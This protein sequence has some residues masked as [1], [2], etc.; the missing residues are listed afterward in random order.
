MSEVIPQTSG[1]YRIEIGKRFYYGSAV[2]LKGRKSTHL[3]GLQRGVHHNPRLL[4]AYRKHQTFKF[5]VV[6]DCAVGELLER[7]QVYLDEFHGHP[8]CMNIASMAGSQLGTKRDETAR[9]KMSEFQRSRPPMSDE[10]KAKVVAALVGRPVSVE[11]R[12]KMSEAQKGIPNPKR[13]H[14]NRPPEWRKMMS[15]RHSGAGNPSY[16]RK[17]SEEERRAMS[18]AV[19]LGKAKA[20]EMAKC[21]TE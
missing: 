14:R 11:T 7:E 10:T 12:R 2:N 6:E 13:G 21:Q 8:L 20:K 3:H 17:Y 19:K 18:E 15:E 1:I 9:K 16:G 4:N 5:E